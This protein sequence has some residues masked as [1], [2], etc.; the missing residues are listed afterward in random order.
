[1]LG[2]GVHCSLTQATACRMPTQGEIRKFREDCQKLH[3][4]SSFKA[5]RMLLP[6]RAWNVLHL[7]YNIADLYIYIFRPIYI[8]QSFYLL[9]RMDDI[10]KLQCHIV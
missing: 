5:G 2:P 9:F 4:Q 7:R 3:K 1:M 6:V 10:I 8:F